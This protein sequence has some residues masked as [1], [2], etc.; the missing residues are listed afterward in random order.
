MGQFDL[1]TFPRGQTAGV[2]ATTDLT[3]LEGIERWFEDIDSANPPKRRSNRRV[4][5]RL[6]RNN[7]GI[8]I[9][10]KRTVRFKA[11]TGGKQVDGYTNTDEGYGAPTDEFLPTAGC[12]DKDLFWVVM[13]GPAIVT[14]SPAGAEASITEGDIL[15]AL[16]AAASTFSTTAGRVYSA[17]FTGANS[18]GAQIANAVLNKIGRALSSVT[19][20]TTN[21]DMLC[22][23]FLIQ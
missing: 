17:T 4:L 3:H 22:D 6:V 8:S 16:T 19:T 9:L 21:G 1:G 23:V 12:P 11:A 10:G 5:C 18:T 7:S 2:A 15:V 20:S 14:N 13:R